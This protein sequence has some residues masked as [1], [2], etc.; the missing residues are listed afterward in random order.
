MAPTTHRLAWWSVTH[1]RARHHSVDADAGG[2]GGR[3]RSVSNMGNTSCGAKS[4]LS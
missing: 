1:R 4:S 2:V 3:V